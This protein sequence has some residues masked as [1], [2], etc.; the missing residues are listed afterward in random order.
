MRFSFKY[1]SRRPCLARMTDMQEDAAA[2]G[3]LT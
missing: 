3:P 2:E 1:R